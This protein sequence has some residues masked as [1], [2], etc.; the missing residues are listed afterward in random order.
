L[1]ADDEIEGMPIWWGFGS[2]SLEQRKNRFQRLT[3]SMI[4]YKPFAIK[5]KKKC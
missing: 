4:W 3:G 2:D 1:S 5:N